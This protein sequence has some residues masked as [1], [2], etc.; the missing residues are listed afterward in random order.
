[1][2]VRTHVDRPTGIDGKFHLISWACICIC[3]VSGTDLDRLLAQLI[4]CV[5]KSIAALHAARRALESQFHHRRNHLLSK[6]AKL[7]KAL[8]QNEQKQSSTRSHLQ[9]VLAE[10]R[11]L[12]GAIKASEHRLHETNE[13]RKHVQ[14]TLRET[15]QHQQEKQ[16][17]FGEQ[18]ELLQALLKILAEEGKEHHEQN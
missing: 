12:A 16:K 15:I 1:M 11:R 2:P 10:L 17:L 7:G 3:L 14:R 5:D 18:L 9:Q 13:E 8:Q 4:A 6:I